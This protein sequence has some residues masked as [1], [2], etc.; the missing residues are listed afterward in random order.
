[1]MRYIHTN[2]IARDWN[3]LAEFYKEVFDCV[4]VPPERDLSGQWLDLA[5]GLRGARIK[6]VHLRL[7]GYGDDGPTLEIFQYSDMPPHR[8]VKPSTP[9]LTHLAFTVDDVRKVQDRVAGMGGGTI[10]DVVNVEIP[11]YGAIEFAYVTDPEKNIIEIQR[12]TSI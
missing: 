3:K 7:P 6:G 4:E 8:E 2:I 12:S 9:G 5:T 1:M 11:G 10:G